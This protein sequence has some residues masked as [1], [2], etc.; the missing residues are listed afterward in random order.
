M[1]IGGFAYR[2]VDSEPSCSLFTVMSRKLMVLSELS[3][4]NL[5]VLW[6]PFKCRT[7]LSNSS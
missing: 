5:M 2:V 4:V 6:H 1:T 7:K 3:T